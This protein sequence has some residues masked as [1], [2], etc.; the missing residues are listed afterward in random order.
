MTQLTINLPDNAYQALQTE[1]KRRGESVDKLIAKCLSL[2]NIGKEQ[3]VQPDW[4]VDFFE[5]TA[6][7]M[8]DD[9]LQREPQGEYEQRRE[10][11]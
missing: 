11:L 7:C 1:A 2:A 4:P 8:Q 6:G 9:P 3:F 10:F 5:K